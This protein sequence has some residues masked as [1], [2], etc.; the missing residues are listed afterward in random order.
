MILLLRDGLFFFVGWIFGLATYGTFASQ[1]QIESKPLDMDKI[2]QTIREEMQ[3]EFDE[4]PLP[5]DIEV[6]EDARSEDFRW[7]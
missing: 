1:R 6:T 5:P 7:H 4:P 2:A 3:R